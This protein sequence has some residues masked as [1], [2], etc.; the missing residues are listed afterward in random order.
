MNIHVLA[1]DSFFYYGL[2]SMLNVKGYDVC[3]SVP[4]TDL[5]LK[6]K[7]NDIILL[8]SSA[9]DF[10]TLSLV[11]SLNNIASTII[12]DSNPDVKLSVF[13]NINT[14]SDGKCSVDKL[15]TTFTNQKLGVKNYDKN[16]IP[17][18]KKEE[19]VLFHVISGRNKKIISRLLNI[20]LKTIYVHQSNALKKIGVR[21]VRDII[22]ID[23]VSCDIV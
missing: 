16:L 10:N 2:K 17:L 18:T 1:N 7:R 8:H 21:R 12:I 14:I 3:R 19:E 22:K 5:N 13:N 9:Y 6:V 11:V 4:D 15:L 23:D 20:S